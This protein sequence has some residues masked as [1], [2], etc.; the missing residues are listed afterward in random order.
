MHAVG[1]ITNLTDLQRSYER[2]QKIMSDD[3]SRL[4]RMIEALGRPN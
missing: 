2:M 3:D 1:E 4:R